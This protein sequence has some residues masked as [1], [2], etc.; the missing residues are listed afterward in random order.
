MLF[1]LWPVAV[2]A[3]QIF[4][5]VRKTS[6]QSSNVV[7][8]PSFDWASNSRGQ[9]PCLVAAYLQAAC[10][11]GQFTVNAL[12]NG[13]HYIGPDPTDVNQCQCST[14]TYSM[15]SACGACQNSTWISW[16]SWSTNCTTIFPQSFPTDIPSGTAVPNWA[17]LNVMASDDFNVTAAKADGDTPEST[18]TRVQSTGSVASSSPT[19][20]PAPT[21]SSGSS[22]GSTS[23]SPSSSHTNAGAIAGGVVGGVVGVG[24]IAAAIGFFVVRS[25]RPKLAPSA[26]YNES[27]AGS[28]NKPRSDYTNSMYQVNPF[29]GQ[30]PMTP[31]RLYD[32]SDPSTFPTS[33][34]TPTIQ[35]TGSNPNAFSP[36]HGYPSQTQFPRPGQYSGAPEI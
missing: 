17:Y 18:A 8:I 20:S 36:S 13:T 19:S 23:G 15:L 2:V 11:D 1:D 9:N 30:S 33:P 26:A 4:S 34:P 24:L 27:V 7:C 21:S 3:L 14:V 29:P 16:S 25:R 12:P 6:A 35:T 31:P 32:P 22:P 28:A 5:V 10:N